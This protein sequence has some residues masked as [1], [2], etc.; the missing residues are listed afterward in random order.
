MRLAIWRPVRAG[1]ALEITVA[2]LVQAIRLGA[3]AVG[4]QLPAERV[5]ADQLQVSRVT[6]RDAIAELRDAGYLESRRGR[7]GG[8]FVIWS[9]GG[10]PGV[11]EDA[12]AV[13]REM[14]D[15]LPDALEFRR[16]LEGGAAGLAASRTLTA[17]DRAQ[18]T[19]ALEA[20]RHRDPQP[21][22]GRTTPS[23]RVRAEPQQAGAAAQARAGVRHRPG[24]APRQRLAAAPGDRVGG[25]VAVAARRHRRRAADPGPAARRHPGAAPQS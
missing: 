21:G 13:A 16:V 1:N 22:E 3:V 10:A 11:R 6:L 9:G 25:R 17:A 15:T 20:S 8:T 23:E 24:A 4:E 7:G 19:A 2:R 12:A 18:L 14:G 5:L